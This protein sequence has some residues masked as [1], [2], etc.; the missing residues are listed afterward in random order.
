MLPENMIFFLERRPLRPVFWLKG[1]SA[2]VKLIGWIDVSIKKIKT[3]NVHYSS[4]SKAEC[5]IIFL[6]KY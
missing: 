1:K 6:T 5:T 2:K 3:G 4:Q